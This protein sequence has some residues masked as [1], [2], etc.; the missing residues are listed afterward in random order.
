MNPDLSRILSD[1]RSFLEGRWFAYKDNYAADFLKPEDD[2]SEDMCRMSS[3]FLR[4]VLP[5]LDCGAWEICGGDGVGEGLLDAGGKW[6]AHSWVVNAQGVIVDLTAS[7]F[8]ESKVV[9]ISPG[10]VG[11]ERYLGRPHAHSSAPAESSTVSEWIEDWRDEQGLSLV[12][13]G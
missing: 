9:V 11:Y 2:H 10:G 13:S 8:G 7:Q 6:R 5:Q 3:T 12:P 1:L 4:E